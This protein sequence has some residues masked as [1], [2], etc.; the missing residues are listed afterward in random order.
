MR[1]QQNKKKCTHKLP[2]SPHSHNLRP[3]KRETGKLVLLVLTSHI[4][5]VKKSNSKGLF[6]QS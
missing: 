2:H 3:S 5:K 6:H 1:D 4:K